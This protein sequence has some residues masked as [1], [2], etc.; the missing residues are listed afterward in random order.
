MVSR[1]VEK[2]LANHETA[3]CIGWCHD[4]RSKLRKLGST[5]EFNLRVQEFIE[6]VRTD[7]R[8]DAVKHARKYFANYD[9]YQLQE[10]QCCMGQLAF[11]AHTY[12]SPYKDLL[13]EKRFAIYKFTIYKQIL[14]I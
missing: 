12:L 1:E 3:R 10:I 4:N 5:M 14:L 7:R 13:D 2:S 8:L 11:P 9:D 6:L